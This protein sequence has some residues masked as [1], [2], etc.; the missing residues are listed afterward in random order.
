[1]L[2]YNDTTSIIITK[3]IRQSKIRHVNCPTHGDGSLRRQLSEN[4]NSSQKTSIIR[5]TFNPT[6]SQ[7]PRTLV[8]LGYINGIFNYIGF[9]LIQCV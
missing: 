8:K 7:T 9:N 5:H 1:M 2:D 4:T 3:I 6:Y